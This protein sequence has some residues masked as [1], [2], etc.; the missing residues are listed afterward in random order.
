MA[1][2]SWHF[3]LPIPSCGPPEGQPDLSLNKARPCL[4]KDHRMSKSNFLLISHWEKET[5]CF[6][7]L[8]QGIITVLQHS[9]PVNWSQCI[10]HHVVLNDLTIT[11]LVGDTITPGTLH[12][13]QKTPR[14]KVR[15]PCLATL[16]QTML[17]KRLTLF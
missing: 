7:L 16:P 15:A 14:G 1:T 13:W 9:C 12:T 5:A 2:R 11:S 17:I 3:P 6:M 10:Y 8:G 4:I